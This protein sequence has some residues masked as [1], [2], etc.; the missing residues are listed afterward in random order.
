MS[1]SP[2]PRPPVRCS[3]SPEVNFKANFDAAL[4]D[5]INNIGIGV[6]V[7]DHLGCVIA[8][9]SQQVKSILSVKMA[10]ALAA[11]R[12]VILAGELSLFNVIFEG[13]C[14]RVIQALQCSG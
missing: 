8:A 6:V 2:A 12:A 13:D 14:V 11:R 3:P 1:P 10:K 7:R 5:G 9:L 4:F